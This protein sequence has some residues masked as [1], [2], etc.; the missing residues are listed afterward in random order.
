MA[1]IW[2]KK[3][4][5]KSLAMLKKLKGGPLW[6]FKQPL[7]QNIKKLKERPF[8]ENFF[9]KSLAMPKKLKGGSFSLARYCMLRGKK[10]KPF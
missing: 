6:I 5:E 4:S 8:G 2:G 7:L 10:E 9:Q 1:K 3:F